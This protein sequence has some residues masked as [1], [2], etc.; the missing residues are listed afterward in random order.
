[1]IYNRNGRV[2][3]L[4]LVATIWYLVMTSVMSV[5]QHYVERHYGKGRA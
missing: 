5:A 1:M 4:L 3:A 2:I